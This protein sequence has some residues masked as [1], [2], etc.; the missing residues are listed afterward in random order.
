M[1]GGG[2]GTVW[3]PIAATDNEL[4]TRERRG[5]TKRRGGWNRNT[6]VEIV[7][8]KKSEIFKKK[9]FPKFPPQNQNFQQEN[10]QHVRG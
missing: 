9:Y 5:N 3:V 7:I 2:G 6:T 4:I 1:S 10:V 8:L